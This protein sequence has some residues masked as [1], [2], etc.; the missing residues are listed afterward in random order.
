MAVQ[1]TPTD[2]LNERQTGGRPSPGIAAPS[3]LPRAELSAR[4]SGDAGR[5]V[6]RLSGGGEHFVAGR[7]FLLLP[8]TATRDG[9]VAFA[10]QGRASSP[11]GATS[12]QSDAGIAAERSPD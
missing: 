4:H 5:L 3:Q 10:E 11:G 8:V 1:L 12:S 2:L 7:K 9:R 6:L